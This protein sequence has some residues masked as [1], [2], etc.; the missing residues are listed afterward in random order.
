M[1]EYVQPSRARPNGG[2]LIL[3]IAILMLIGLAM[4]FMLWGRAAPKTEPL[5]DKAPVKTSA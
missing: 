3:F 2:C 4:W 1:D 5:P